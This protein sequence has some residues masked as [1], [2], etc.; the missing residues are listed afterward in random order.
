MSR[1][2]GIGLIEALVALGL[3]G[4]IAVS[5]LGAISTGLNGAGMI[6]ERLTAESIART[7]IEEIKSLPYND[8]NQ[9]SVTVSPPP[10]Y[11]VSIDITDISPIEYPST[12]QKVAVKVCREGQTV[13]SVESYKFKR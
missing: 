10:G 12:L 7:Q 6:D 9:Y 1:Q 11:A 4:M 5:F 2:R 13:L 8:S 3:F